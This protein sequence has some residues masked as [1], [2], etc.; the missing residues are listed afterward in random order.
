MRRNKIYNM[1]DELPIPKAKHDESSHKH[2]DYRLR[3]GPGHWDYMH[4]CAANADNDVRKKFII[5][6]LDMQCISFGCETCRKD[7]M[8]LWVNEYSHNLAE[9]W[10]RYY[11]MKGKI[12]DVGM[13]LL[14]V[15][16][17]N[18]VNKK[19]GKPC[20]DYDTAIN[21]YFFEACEDYVCT[22]H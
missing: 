3:F 18:E 15:D 8:H 17:H 6:M 16:L 14:T 9:Y 10:N 20:M 11:K 2:D 5:D 4:R 12:Y 7:F 1:L 19:L 21:K 13:L 22:D